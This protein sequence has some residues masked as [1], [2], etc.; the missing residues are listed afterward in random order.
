MRPRRRTRLQQLGLVA[1]IIL[2]LQALHWGS[3]VNPNNLP[4][5]AD[6]GRAIVEAF[7]SGFILPHI[8]A[9]YRRVFLAFG[10]AV[11]IGF[12][13]GLALWRLPSNFSRAMEPFLA[14][15]YAIPWIAFY[16]VMMVLMGLG[17]SPIIVNASLLGIIPIALNTFQ[18]FRSIEHTHL[19]VGRVS[20]CSRSQ[21]LT[22]IMLPAA[23]PFIV[24]GLKL[25]FI[26]AYLGVVG[27]EFLRSAHGLGF[28]VQSAYF[29]FQN[30]NM[31]A[32]V[33]VIGLL[34]LVMGYALDRVEHAVGGRFR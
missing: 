29:F 14:S 2:A 7:T 3:L 9:T 30:T 16:P 8:A 11:A 34:T 33:V 10:L 32:Y 25:G 1:L 12:P 28:I 13:V 20:G 23:I 17:E 21:M 18:G 24:S 4:P 15:L 6:I 31:Y 22:K 19:K 27:T 5:P 26:Y